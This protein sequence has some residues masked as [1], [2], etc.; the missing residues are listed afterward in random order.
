MLAGRYGSSARRSGDQR[1]ERDR[2]DYSWVD[3]MPRR[4]TPTDCVRKTRCGSVRKS[5]IWVATNAAQT[6]L[7]AANLFKNSVA[8]R[9]RSRHA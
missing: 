6:R 5:S 1:H 3:R 2:N 4:L 9:L 7:S 8:R